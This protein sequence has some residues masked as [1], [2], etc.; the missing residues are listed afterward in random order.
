MLEKM[1]DCD[2]ESLPALKTALAALDTLMA[3]EHAAL[4]LFGVQFHRAHFWQ[5]VFDFPQNGLHLYNV[6]WI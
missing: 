2:P 3:L 4:P 6:I 5:A 1:E